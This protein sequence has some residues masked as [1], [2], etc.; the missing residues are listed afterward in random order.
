LLRVRA[1]ILDDPL[2]P[3]FSAPPRA[4]TLWRTE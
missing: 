1:R 3:R 2:L 4:S